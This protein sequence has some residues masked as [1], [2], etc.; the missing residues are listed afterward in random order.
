MTCEKERLDLDSVHDEVW[1][2]YY[3]Q[4]KWQVE[5]C[6]HAGPAARWLL[7]LPST[8]LCLGKG[9]RFELPTQST[10]QPFKTSVPSARVVQREQPRSWSLGFQSKPV[11]LELQDCVRYRC[12][13]ARSRG[14]R[15]WAA[16][17]QLAALWGLHQ[18][19]RVLAST[20]PGFGSWEW[21]CP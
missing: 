6:K 8:S 2:V 21:A 17:A 15:C 5:E 1:H 3:G 12:Y 11:V 10:R 16:Q 19:P 4:L 13:L 9:R 18:L 20:C 14:W 7:R